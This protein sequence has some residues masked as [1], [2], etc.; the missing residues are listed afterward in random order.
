MKLGLDE[1]VPKHGLTLSLSQVK[2]ER[3]ARYSRDTEGKGKQ[4]FTKST[5]GSIN[6]LTGYVA[7]AVAVGKERLQADHRRSI[8]A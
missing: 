4:R 7:S 3:T 8:A 5:G 1:A 6:A 2:R